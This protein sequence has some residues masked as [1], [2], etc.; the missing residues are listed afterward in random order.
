MVHGPSAAKTIDG[1]SGHDKEWK[2]TVPGDG[3]A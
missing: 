1:P 2:V 3:D